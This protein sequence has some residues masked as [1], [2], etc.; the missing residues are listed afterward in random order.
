MRPAHAEQIL[1]EQMRPK[2]G[3]KSEFG[4]G[5]VLLTADAGG[6][7]RMFY[8]CSSA[9][10]CGYTSKRGGQTGRRCEFV[11]ELAVDFRVMNT[12]AA[13]PV[14]GVN[15]RWAGNFVGQWFHNIIGFL[16]RRLPAALARLWRSASLLLVAV[17]MPQ[18]DQA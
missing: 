14:G 17:R 6:W 18:R 3:A 4:A 12:L 15:R 5:T 16:E 1:R 7:T 13:E 10:I 2:T 8:L 11:G 9:S